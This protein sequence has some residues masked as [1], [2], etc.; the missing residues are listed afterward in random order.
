MARADW[1][2]VSRPWAMAL[3]VEQVT[4]SGTAVGGRT[5]LHPTYSFSL[6][7]L[8]IQP[9]ILCGPGKPR[10]SCHGLLHIREASWLDLR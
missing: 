3:L 8:G 5:A 9:R 7:T 1:A 6:S 2:R 10:P 4:V